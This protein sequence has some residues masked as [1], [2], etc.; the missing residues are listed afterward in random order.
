MPGR[1]TIMITHD[2]SLAADADRILVIDHGRL[3][4]TG[5]HEQL[6]ARGGAYA[7]P[8]SPLPEAATAPAPRGDDTLVLRW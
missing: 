3:V 8:A 6:L 5:T 4:E 1:T 2:L 7:R